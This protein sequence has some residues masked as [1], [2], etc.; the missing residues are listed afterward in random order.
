MIA[1]ALTVLFWYGSSENISFI[2]S[3]YGLY[4]DIGVILLAIV[5]QLIIAR[6]PS[7]TRIWG[8]VML[9]AI[10]IGEGINLLSASSN[11]LSGP[12]PAA[13]IPLGWPDFWEGVPYSAIYSAA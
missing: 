2:Q 5:G 12:L 10:I 11:D 1:S 8:R 7:K 3:E 13:R 4:W 6:S 9:L